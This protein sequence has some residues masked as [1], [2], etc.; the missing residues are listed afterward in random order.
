MTASRSARE[1]EL[2]AE[3]KLKEFVEFVYL[4][5]FENLQQT[6]IHINA[7]AVAKEGFAFF[8]NANSGFF[9]L[10]HNHD[11]NFENGLIDE[12]QRLFD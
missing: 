4:D 12:T 2:L 8:F 1:H 6:V 3:T 10:S 9:E 7:V 11:M 5:A